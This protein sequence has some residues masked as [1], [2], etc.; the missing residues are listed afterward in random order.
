VTPDVLGIGVDEVR[1]VEER[2]DEY[3]DTEFGGLGMGTA[4][5]AHR[6]AGNADM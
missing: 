1:D 2:D 5:G 3:L 6:W 4:T